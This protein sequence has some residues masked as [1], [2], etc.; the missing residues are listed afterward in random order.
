[1]TQIRQAN[2]EGICEDGIANCSPILLELSMWLNSILGGSK[3]IFSMAQVRRQV[4][5]EIVE[6]SRKV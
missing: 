6:G 3:S 1:M 4:K 2:E 5:R